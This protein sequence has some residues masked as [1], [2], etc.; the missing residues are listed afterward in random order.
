M[1]TLDVLVAARAEVE[2]GWCKK[3]AVDPRGNVCAHGGL[4]TALGIPKLPRRNCKIYPGAAATALAMALPA[5]YWDVPGFNDDPHTTKADVLA[6]YSRAIN[7][8]M[9]RIYAEGKSIT[10]IATE[11]G[12]GYH[13][14]RSGLLEH[15]V[16]LRTFGAREPLEPTAELLALAER[17]GCECDDFFIRFWSKVE[18]GQGCWEWTGAKSSA[19]YGSCARGGE[20]LLA[21]RVAF[22][23][24]FGSLGKQSACHRCDN[25][26]CVNPFHLFAGTHA[27]NM[28]DA[29]AK[30]RMANENTH[31]THCKRGHAFAG[32]NLYSAANGSRQCKE[33]R[34]ETLRQSRA[35]RSGAVAS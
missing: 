28:A 12:L 30:G 5:W 6:L 7:A 10:T 32:E 16:T 9:A 24:C 33:C 26:S 4:E 22:E 31:K 21:H 3:V 15:G 23:M 8:E 25:P 1:E 27:E 19:G 14:V 2:A 13:A 20:R 17:L 35:R 34:R 11:H 18:R 29:K